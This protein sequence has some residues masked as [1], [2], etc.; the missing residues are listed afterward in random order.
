MSYL[1]RSF[2]HS[3][4][5]HIIYTQNVNVSHS[6]VQIQV[7][8]FFNNKS[9]TFFKSLPNLNQSLLIDLLIFNL[10]HCYK[11]DM[12]VHNFKYYLIDLAS[13]WVDKFKLK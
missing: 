11:L 12:K 10:S 9:I 6:L 4:L 7:H 1:Q 8:N 2:L 13:E 3:V 5:T